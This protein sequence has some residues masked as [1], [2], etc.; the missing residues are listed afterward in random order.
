MTEKR[1]GTC[2]LCQQTGEL[3]KSHIVPRYVARWQRETAPGFLRTPGN[4]NRRIQDLLKKR[5]LCS[6]CE[7]RLS[8]WEKAFAEN[9]FR[10]IHASETLPRIRYG[11]YCLKY[12]VSASL[13]VV[14]FLLKTKPD[15]WSGVQERL[16]REAVE[17]WRDFLL[18]KDPHPGRFEHH[19]IPFEVITT[20]V[21]TQVSP[22]LNR[23]L[24]RAT[25]IDV[26]KSDKS[27]YVLSKHGKIMFFGFIQDGSPRHWSRESK[28]SVNAGT[29]AP[30]NFEI[31]PLLMEYINRR[32]DQ[33]GAAM[34]SISSIQRAKIRNE[35]EKNPE[36]WQSSELGRAVWYDRLQHGDG[37]THFD[38]GQ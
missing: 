21:S 26:P 6:E 17:T 31:P 2:L 5:L 30:A 27:A 11:P 32:A 14:G 1:L 15:Y 4:P 36:R 20:R 25:D 37:L 24:I 38:H 12:A 10:P 9:I 18:D 35:Y 23:Y 7:E 28:I 34:R 22:Y 29:I 16:V 3:Q 33:A 13:R 8:V 19:L